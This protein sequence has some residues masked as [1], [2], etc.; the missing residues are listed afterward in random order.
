[1]LNWLCRYAPV[2]KLVL[3]DSGGIDTSLLDVG[4]GPHG[5]ACAS[6]SV[7]FV[8]MDTLFPLPA[9]PSMVA[10]KNR[11]GP[12]PFRDGAFGTVISLDV[13][14]HVPPGDRRGFVEEMT[15]VSANR[16][17][18]A[19]PSS[20]MAAIDDL[21]R[22][23]FVR[24]GRPVPDWLSEHDEHGLPTPDEMDA[25]CA[26][27]AGFRRRPLEVPNGLLSTMASI[28]DFLADTE[29]MASYEATY[30]SE[31]WLELF[32]SSAFGGSWRKGYV[33]ERL[34]PVEP[35]VDHANLLETT[36]SALTCPAC[37]GGFDRVAEQAF[38]CRDC[39]HE[40]VR[41]HCGAWDIGDAPE[42]SSA[43]VAPARR[44]F[45]LEPD[46]TPAQIAPV[47]H[48][49]ADL[50]DADATLVLRGSPE[51]ITSA[52]ALACATEALG[53]RELAGDVDVVL[54]LDRLSPAEESTLRDTATVIDPASFAGF[55]QRD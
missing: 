36:L 3:D 33:F 40:V 39:A 23:L 31:R 10:I 21:V 4:S 17:I 45:W 9:A 28:V 44:T 49:F 54:L 2:S 46:W 6:P 47:L 35:L 53:G 52:D 13:L 26:A 37:G 14:E 43:P 16:V 27:P 15:R 24:S 7:P 50:D 29:A 25:F 1:M 41:D 22:D 12:F 55:P 48:A 34:D 51:Q 32:A 11:P 38:E 20:E 8:G 19:C 18:V 5:F 30:H 42:A